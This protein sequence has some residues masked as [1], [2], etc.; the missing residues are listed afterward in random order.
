MSRR[1]SRGHAQAFAV[2]MLGLDPQIAQLLVE[3]VR[4]G[5]NHVAADRDLLYSALQSPRLYRCNQAA[6]YSMP[7]LC[8]VHHQ[9]ENLAAS[10]GLQQL[11]LRAVYPAYHR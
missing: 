2:A 7:P 6:A 3:G 4:L 5:S 1:G 11:P 10:S 9:T 8:L